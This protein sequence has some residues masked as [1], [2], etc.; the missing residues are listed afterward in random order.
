MLQTDQDKFTWI[1]DIIYANIVAKLRGKSFA[2]VIDTGTKS[3]NL[4]E[5][6]SETMPDSRLYGFSIGN[7]QTETIANYRMLSSEDVKKYNYDLILSVFDLHS[8]NLL[9]ISDYLNFLKNLAD[10]ST[11]IILSD[12]ACLTITSRVFLWCASLFNPN[13]RSILP[14]SKVIE[15][16]NDR[17]F[18]IIENDTYKINGLWSGWIIVAKV[19]EPS[20]A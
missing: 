18:D 3:A 2:N 20:H 10:K 17:N 1:R 6:L 12:I 7:T 8:L 5:K 4:L 19:K 11:T 15:Y 9:N 13:L 16:L 14:L